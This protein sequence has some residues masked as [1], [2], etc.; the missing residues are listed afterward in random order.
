M[1]VDAAPAATFEVIQTEFFLRFTEA[2]FHRPATE[3]H[4]KNL[5][6]RSAVTA[7][8]AV[9]KKV[10]GFVGEHVASHDQRALIADKIVCVSFTPA[11]GPADF[12]DFATTMRVLD[13]IVLRCLFSK[14]G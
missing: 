6:Q 11:G 1:A 10:F 4:A 9:R 7:R 13:L 8:H 12:P 2:V 3:R 14:R 5:P